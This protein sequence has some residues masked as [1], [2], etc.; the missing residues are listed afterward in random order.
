MQH[1]EKLARQQLD[2]QTAPQPAPIGPDIDAS[3]QSAKQRVIEA[4]Q[5]EQEKAA[6]QDAEYVTMLTSRPAKYVQPPLADTCVSECLRWVHNG[7]SVADVEHRMKHENKLCI[8]AGKM[9]K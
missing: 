3:V 9:T 1:A 8:S 2:A 7:W 4:R 6:R 5:R